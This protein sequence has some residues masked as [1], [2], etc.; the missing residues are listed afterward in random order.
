MLNS[1]RPCRKHLT[2]CTEILILRWDYIKFIDF[3]SAMEV[4]KNNRELFND[5]LDFS[6][7]KDYIR[8]LISRK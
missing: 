7:N 8:Q 1:S 6:F 5:S 4:I 3:Y 2:W